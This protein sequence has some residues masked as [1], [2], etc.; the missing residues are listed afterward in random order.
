MVLDLFLVRSVAASVEE[1]LGLYYPA[2]FYMKLII[3][4]A[5]PR[6]MAIAV[7]SDLSC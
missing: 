4:D 5:F 7:N 2:L 1:S 6:V 3:S